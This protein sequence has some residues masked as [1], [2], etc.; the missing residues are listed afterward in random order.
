MEKAVHVVCFIELFQGVTL[1]AANGKPNV[2]VILADRKRSQQGGL[3]FPFLPSY[4]E[5]NCGSSPS[6][7]R[8]DLALLPLRQGSSPG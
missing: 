6:P 7:S 5:S 8:T 3:N 4:P 1:W 2:L